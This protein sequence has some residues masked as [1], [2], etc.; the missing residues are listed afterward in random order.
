MNPSNS[1]YPVFIRHAARLLH[2]AVP[3]NRLRFIMKRTPLLVAAFVLVTLARAFAGNTIVCPS[4]RTGNDTVDWSQLGPPG[5]FVNSGFT[6]TASPV[7]ITLT[8]SFFG[9]RGLPIGQVLQEGSGGSGGFLGDFAIGDNLLSTVNYFFS[10][11][12]QFSAGISQVGTQVDLLNS[13]IPRQVIITA[14]DQSSKQLGTC[15]VQADNQGKQDNS[16]PYIGIAEVDGNNNPVAGIYAVEI[17]TYDLPIVINTL[18]LTTPEASTDNCTAYCSPT[19]ARGTSDPSKCSK[20]PP[21]A[22]DI[23]IGPYEDLVDG[24]VNLLYPGV[25]TSTDDWYVN[26]PTLFPCPSIGGTAPPRNDPT[27]AGVPDPAATNALAERLAAQLPGF[28]HFSGPFP[29]MVPDNYVYPEQTLLQTSCQNPEFF[30]RHGE[31]C[32]ALTYSPFHGKD[33]IYVHGFSPDVIQ[34][35]V[36]GK[37]YPTW[38][39][40]PADFAPGGYWRKLGAEYWDDPGV[41]K[42]HIQNFLIHRNGILRYAKNRYMTVGWSTAQGLETDANAILNQ[43]ADAMVTGDGVTLTDP[44]DP[45]FD[46]MTHKPSG[47][48]VAG[49]IVISHSIGAPLTDVAMSFA[50]DPVYQKQQ[51]TGPIGFIPKHIKVHAALAGTISGSQLATTAMVLAFGLTNDP[52]VCDVATLFLLLHTG[53]CNSF[54]LLQDSVLWDLVPQVMQTQWSSRINDTPVPVLTVAGAS[55]HL[56]W[57]LKY[58]FQRGFDDGVVT[59]DSA[60]GRTVPIWA[61]PSG[62]YSIFPPGFNEIDPSSLWCK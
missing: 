6:A 22:T 48:C 62:F 53:L 17:G 54:Y 8:G 44:N 60:C 1:I 52:Y 51:Q 3:T 15:T 42:S 19:D 12:L 20:L 59:M 4:A 21:G 41:T 49:C 29:P 43:I 31:F 46:P 28:L 2:T 56:L 33:I 47:F 13:G 9:G 45:R 26:N 57:P 58:F 23:K 30:E 40:D 14:Y 61:W 50:A 38:P 7:P 55:D 10:L 16:A 5:T 11:T 32:N 39:D 25:D 37:G 36:S 27:I 34:G 18:S 24:P 35:V